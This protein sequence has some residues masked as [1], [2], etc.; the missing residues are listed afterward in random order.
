MTKCCYYSSKDIP[1]FITFDITLLYKLIRNLC[2]KLSPSRDWGKVLTE[3]DK[4]VVHDI[5]R[6][7]ELRNEHYGHT[8]SANI[9]NEDYNKLWEKSQCIIQRCEAFTKNHCCKPKY[10][11]ELTKLK[12]NNI[13]FQEYQLCKDRSRGKHCNLKYWILTSLCWN[14]QLITFV[15]N[16]FSLAIY[17]SGKSDVLYGEVACF[18]VEITREEYV[19]FLVSWNKIE[20][21][22]RVDG[23]VRVE[24]NLRSDKYKGSDHR[25]L[26]IHNVCKED[27]AGYEA[28]ITG[29][30]NYK[31]AS[32]EIVLRA[33]GGI[34]LNLKS[35]WIH[36]LFW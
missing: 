16:F 24:L 15:I 6:I 34:V 11:E 33:S 21:H 3:D 27:E 23:S 25:Q 1:D 13:T 22:V 20:G 32:N 10:N 18:K 9:S 14:N 29:D 26:L 19:D 2:Y 31:I 17:I 12:K 30:R 28:V 7:R 5:N 8:H 35:K 36:V 4:G